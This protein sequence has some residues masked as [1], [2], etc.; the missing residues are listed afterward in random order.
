MEVI[1]MITIILAD[2]LIDG[3]GRDP[4][5]DAGV[6]I[7]NGRIK[8]VGD[9]KSISFDIKE[10]Q[11]IDVEEGVI[12]PGLID[13]H[14]HLFSISGRP[15][16]GVQ[17]WG[18]ELMVKFIADGLESARWWLKQGVTTVRDLGTFMNLDLGLRDL[19]AKGKALGP[20]IFGSGRP[21]IMTGRETLGGHE[22]NSATE[23][24]RAARQQLH[25]GS[26]IIKLFASS[27]TGGALGK[28]I[29]PPGWT[30]LT[31]EELQAA[32]SEAHKAGLT[33]ACHAS[34]AES[35]KNALR[36]G[37]DSIEHGT[38]MDE[39][40]LEMMKTRDVVLVPTLAVGKSLAKDDAAS[41]YGPHMTE[42]AKLSTKGKKN[43]MKMAYD[44]GVRIA[45][46]SDP[47]EKDTLA[48]ECIC[49]N[50]AGLSP[51][52]VIAAA[53]RI[54]AELLGVEDRLGTVEEGKIADLII[55]DGNPLDDI[56]AIRLIRNVIQGGK[57]VE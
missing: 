14:C 29:G 42:K 5:R 38:F 32:T 11:V 33:V 3:T 51:M 48:D 18:P 28:L 10:D 34:S 26:D 52:E 27:G 43:T 54:G 6:I 24:R 25:A 4:V 47:T 30:Q 39:E 31:F 12:L 9:R 41:R 45:A 22:V 37:V 36:A 8:Q 55:L 23:A 13:S 57:M 44:A 20:R 40:G 35:I 56:K 16:I 49:L 1:L 50:E 17:E 21:I 2:L 53:T 15:V 7:E 19:I 46:G